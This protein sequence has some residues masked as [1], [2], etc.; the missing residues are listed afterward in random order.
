MGHTNVF[1]KVCGPL[2]CSGILIR[3]GMGLCGR[4]GTYALVINLRLWYYSPC[5]IIL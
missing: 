3:Y 2:A 1:R 4:Q 5:L